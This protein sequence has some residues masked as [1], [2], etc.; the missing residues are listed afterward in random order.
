MNTRQ[1]RRTAPLFTA[2]L[3]GVGLAAAAC[4]GG[5]APPQSTRRRFAAHRGRTGSHAELAGEDE[6]DVDQE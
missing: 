5:T 2:L 1:R 3:A 4:G 6:P